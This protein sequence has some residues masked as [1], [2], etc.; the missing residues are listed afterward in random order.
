MN[1]VEE[2]VDRVDWEHGLDFLNPL[3]SREKSDVGQLFDALAF[4]FEDEVNDM[5]QK[6]TTIDERRCYTDAMCRA[7][8]MA[9]KLREREDTR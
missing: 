8:D 6:G 5:V 7:R 9:S 1:Q 2:K 4:L 3:L